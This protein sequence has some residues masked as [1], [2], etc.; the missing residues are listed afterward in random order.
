[1]NVWYF[2]K[3]FFI[4]FFNNSQFSIIYH[5]CV[6]F[7]PFYGQFSF[8]FGVRKVQVK[9]VKNVKNLEIYFYSKLLKIGIHTILSLGRPVRCL[10]SECLT[11]K[12][13]VE[14]LPFPPKCGT[15]AFQC[16]CLPI[17]FTLINNNKSFKYIW[18]LFTS[19]NRRILPSIPI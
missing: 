19:Q 14:Y 17:N 4:K 18:N 16:E 6:Q 15:N 1:M 11:P 13:S 5:C 2:S 9:S 7:I 12:K 3:R 10:L 8:H